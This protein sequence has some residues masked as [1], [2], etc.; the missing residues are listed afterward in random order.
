MNIIGINSAYHESSVAAII[1]GKLECFIEE[2]RVNRVK[3]AKVA[4]VNNPHELPLGALKLCMNNLGLTVNDIDF[5][6]Y[7]F[8]EKGRLENINV[9]PFFQPNSWGSEKGEKKFHNN[10]MAVTFELCNYFNVNIEN[11]VVYVDHHLSHAGSA[12]LCS[13]YNEAAVIVVDG[14]G[15]FKTISTYLG[16]DNILTELS[17]LVYPDS[18]GFL[19]EKM[20]KYLGFSEYDAYKI[21]GLSS[22]GNAEILHDKFSKFVK[23]DENGYF[24]IN[25]N[26]LKFRTEDY[27]EIERILGKRRKPDEPITKHHKNIAAT[28]QSYT[29]SII[30][31]IGKELQKKTSSK[32]LCVAG[33]TA[34]NCV[35]NS[36]LLRDSGFENIFIQPASND[37]GTALGAALYLYNSIL[38]HDRC[39]VQTHS[40]YGIEYSNEKILKAISNHNLDSKYIDEPALVAAKLISEGNIVGWFQGEMEMGPRALGNRSLL[41]DPRKKDMREIL[42][43]KIKHREDFRPF[44][45]SVL[46]ESANEWFEIP[47][48]SLST[49]FM[50]YTFKVKEDKINKIPAVIHVDSTS[51]IQTIDKNTNHEYH[52]LV[53][54][55]DRI[56]GIPMVL[57]TSFNDQE[58]I[59]MSPDDAIKTFLRTGIDYLF[60]GNYIISKG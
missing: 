39:F 17:S 5:F 52:K 15:E 38:K 2:E 6:A 24:K 50:L 45:P 54:E 19:W 23:E 42:N 8:S 11:K 4:T 49:D 56:T 10:L 58:P 31:K 29:S 55:F 18:L 13:P 33:G 7:S 27:E 36:I 59:V 34:L 41:A 37:A 57:N 26:I 21:M 25:N 3:H 51:R 60:L 1:D 14:I 48:E 47:K 44:A 28:L 30:L 12:F 35:A 53:R 16:K 46:K 32:N 22:Y 9:D 43:R 40:Y 20:C